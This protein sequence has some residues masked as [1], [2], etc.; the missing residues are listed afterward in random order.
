[1]PGTHIV[2][3]YT[4]TLTHS[5]LCDPEFF[6]FSGTICLLLHVSERIKTKKYYELIKYTKIFKKLISFYV[7]KLKVKKGD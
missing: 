5:L 3:I 7:K 2:C 6:Y 1:M 4:H